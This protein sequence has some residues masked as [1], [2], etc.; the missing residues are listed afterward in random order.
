MCVCVY[1]RKRAKR[2]E[3]DNDADRQYVNVKSQNVTHS[4]D[5]LSKDPRRISMTRYIILLIKSIV[6]SV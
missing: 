5:R 6:R 1:E 2:G 4:T 3:T